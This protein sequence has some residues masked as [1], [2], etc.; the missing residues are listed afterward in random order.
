MLSI[1]RAAQPDLRRNHTAA[2]A[3]RG[4]LNSAS[5]AL[6]LYANAT[7]FGNNFPCCVCAQVFFQQEVIPVSEVPALSTAQ[8]LER[9][10]TAEHASQI[11][12]FTWHGQLWCCRQCAGPVTDG[13]LPPMAA[14]N[15]LDTSWSWPDNHVL[16]GL[17]PL[18]RDV[19]SPAQPF[20]KVV[21]PL[22]SRFYFPLLGDQLEAGR[23]RQRGVP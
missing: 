1:L 23:R 6:V 11:D 3:V 12:V 7:S 15:C 13:Q 22:M 14:A 16:N 10:L 20:R 4:R 2:R 9:Y 8:G 21:P 5:D 17:T 19:L 18:E